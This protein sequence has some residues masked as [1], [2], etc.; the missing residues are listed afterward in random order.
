MSNPKKPNWLTIALVVSMI[1]N[2]GT[3]Y[4]WFQAKSK[5]ASLEQQLTTLQKTQMD[6]ETQA[7]ERQKDLENEATA[8]SRLLGGSK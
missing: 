2:V 1:F 5:M 7:E 3:I 6:T 8:F 4:Y